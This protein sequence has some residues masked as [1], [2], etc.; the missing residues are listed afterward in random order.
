MLRDST[1]SASVTIVNGY[2]APQETLHTAPKLMVSGYAVNL[3]TIYA[4]DDFTLTVFI[5][6]TSSSASAVNITGALTLDPSALMA[7]LGKSDTGY[8]AK[9]APGDTAEIVYDLT[10]MPD[11][12][13]NAQIAIKLEYEDKENTA[14]SVTQ[15]ITLP[16]KQRMRISVDQPEVFAEGATEGDYI[17]VSLPIVNKGKTK[18]YNVEVKLESEKLSMSESYYGGDILPG[19]KQSAEFQLLCLKGG[20]ADGTLTVSFED[21]EGNVYEQSV[22]IQVDVAETI[23]IPAAADTEAEQPQE[24]SAFPIWI[25]AVGAVAVAA[26]AAAL[27]IKKGRSNAAK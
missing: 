1:L 26:I 2:E 4:G 9:I 22:P 21:A 10:A 24:K 13:G 23:S 3:D 11:I 14:A 20:M 8:A 15:T 27:I 5:K 7:A 16:I 6:N 17:A 18:A 25:V 19:A 12:Q